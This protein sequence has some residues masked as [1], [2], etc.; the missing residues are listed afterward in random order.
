MVYS[1]R[2]NKIQIGDKVWC[3]ASHTK[4][5]ECGYSDIEITFL[6]HTF[7]RVVDIEPL[8]NDRYDRWVLSFHESCN[9]AGGYHPVKIPIHEVF[10]EIDE[11]NEPEGEYTCEEHNWI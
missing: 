8:C 7:G 2:M 5:D 4:L 10:L 3:T 1:V 11:D 6:Q 9:F